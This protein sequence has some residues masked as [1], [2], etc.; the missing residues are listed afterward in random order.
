VVR[1]NLTSYPFY[2]MVVAAGE[3]AQL[4]EA[5]SVP[6]IF[7]AEAAP[8][9]LSLVTPV[10]SEDHQE[11]PEIN[12]VLVTGGVKPLIPQLFPDVPE[13]HLQLLATAAA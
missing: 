10:V 6:T 3:T 13:H 7:V 1:V 2:L 12:L 5:T 9:L 11:I 4:P 8:F